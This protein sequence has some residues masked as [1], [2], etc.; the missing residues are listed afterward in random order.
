ME[1]ILISTINPDKIRSAKR[2]PYADSC[3][4]MYNTVAKK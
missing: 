2:N 4:C 1:K 3:V